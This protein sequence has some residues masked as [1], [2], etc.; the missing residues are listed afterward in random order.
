MSGGGIEKQFASNHFRHFLLT[1]LLAEKLLKAG[2][3]A[4]GVKVA[5]TGFEI[6]GVR[7]GDW[8]FK[9]S[10]LSKLLKGRC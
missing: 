2:R 9:V 3:R 7:F 1:N 8:N 4:R 10:F 6:Y 5:S